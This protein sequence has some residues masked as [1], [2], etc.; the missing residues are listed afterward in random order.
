MR[1][2]PGVAYG[3]TCD[4]S[5]GPVYEVKDG[6]IKIAHACHKP[7]IVSRTWCKRR[8]TLGGW[9][10]AVIPL[11][12]NHIVQAFAGPYFVPPEADDPE[13]LERFRLYIQRELLELTWWVHER[14]GDVPEQPFFGFPADF[15][16][17]WGREP[18]LPRYPF[19]PEPGHPA[20]TQEKAVP[21]RKAAQRRQA[22]AVARQG[23]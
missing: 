8:I 3:I 22:A 11:P 15:E 9:D 17:T 14:I 4:G 20:L 2:F 1:E 16:P 5:K 19:V 7:M 10:R 12:F 23:A 18:E 6:T 13:V 21:V